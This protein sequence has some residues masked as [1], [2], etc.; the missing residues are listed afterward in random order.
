M[1]RILISVC[2]ILVTLLFVGCSGDL[3][4]EGEVIDKNY[5]PA[6]QYTTIIPIAM[7]NGKITTTLFIPYIYRYS[8]K[9]E[10][11]IQNWDD[12][13]GVML[14]AKY[15]VTQSC[16]DGVNLGDEFIYTDEATPDY[17]EYI[18]EKE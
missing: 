4:K 13:S 3:I 6:H 9:W 5:T 10:I 15:R 18:R 7:Y 8:D 17:P 1:K 16:Y 14:E 12:K 2:V 11:T